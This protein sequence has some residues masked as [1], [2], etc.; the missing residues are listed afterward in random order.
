MRCLDAVN[1][2]IRYSNRRSHGLD[3]EVRKAEKRLVLTDFVA[4]SPFD[5]VFCITPKRYP[6]DRGYLSETYRKDILLSQG[7]DIAFVQDNQSLSRHAGT[8]R[9]LHFQRPPHAQ[10]KLVR[11]LSGAIL[12]VVV[13]LRRGSPHFGA[14]ASVKIDAE[15]GAQL[16]VPV[17][18]AHGFCTLTPDCLVHYKMSR[19]YVPDAEGG[20]LWNDPAL[21]IDWPV[22]ASSARLSPKDEILPTLAK[23][24]SPFVFSDSVKEELP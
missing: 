8:I 7:I 6:D 17:G 4:I 22:D 16:F 3:G 12:D 10:A 18:F 14:H 9:G 2:P 15:S 23:L 13:D 11:C 21:A 20:I 19:H 1:R 24:Q 5:D